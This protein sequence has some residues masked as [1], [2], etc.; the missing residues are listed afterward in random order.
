MR[1]NLQREW[2]YTH[3]SNL[4][5]W[6]TVPRI[7]IDKDGKIVEYENIWRDEEAKKLFDRWGELLRVEI[8]RDC[9]DQI[10]YHQRLEYFHMKKR[11]INVMKGDDIFTGDSIFLPK[12]R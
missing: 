1:R 9:L 7:I 12:M 11:M 4:Y 5:I 6:F 8:E 3:M 10:R 2:L